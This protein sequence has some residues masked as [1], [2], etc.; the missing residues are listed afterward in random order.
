[1]TVKIASWNVRGLNDPTKQKEVKNF[2]SKE[3][4]H[5]IGVLETKIKQ[6]NERKIC[7]KCFGN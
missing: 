3:N 1:M 7:G 2:V 5:V 6:P 4:V